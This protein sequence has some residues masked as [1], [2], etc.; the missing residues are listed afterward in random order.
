[1]RRGHPIQHDLSAAE[2]YRLAQSVRRDFESMQ[3]GE[4]WSLPTLSPMVQFNLK[5]RELIEDYSGPYHT[6]MFTVLPIGF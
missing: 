1:M 6:S 4:R 5:T 2:I 3:K